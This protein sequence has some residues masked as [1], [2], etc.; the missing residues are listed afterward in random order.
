MEAKEIIE[1]TQRRQLIYAFFQGI[2]EM[3]AGK[4]LI[5]CLSPK[6]KPILAIADVFPSEETRQLIR[7]LVLFT[8][9][10]PSQDLE[11]VH[12]KLGTDYAALFLGKDDV[13]QPPTESSYTKGTVSSHPLH[14]VRGLYHGFGMEKKEEFDGPEDHIAVELGF[15]AHLCGKTVSA[16][17]AQNKGE[18]LKYMEAQKEFLENHLIKWVPALAKDII[19]AARTPFYQAIAAIIRDF[20]G[21]DLSATKGLLKEI[22]QQKP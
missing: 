1:L 9:A 18:A 17:K 4:A 13:Y 5:S 19:L 8:D 16:L 7:E 22:E 21:L 20:L 3:E 15:I 11:T 12:S 14:E 10:I 2:F 6:I